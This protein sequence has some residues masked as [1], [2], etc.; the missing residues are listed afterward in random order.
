MAEIIGRQIEFGVATE[1]TRGTAE[2]AA[3]KWARQ[4]SATVVE[5][6]THAVDD[7]T[8]GRIEAG[9]GR[10]VT[11]K[12]IEGQI[13]GILHIDT[14]GW[15]LSNI[16]GICNST[17]VDDPITDHVFT[18]KQ[19]IEHTSLSLFAKDGTVQQHVFNNCMV[20][21]LT[22]NAAIDAY[23]R[24]TATFIGSDAAT[25]SDTPSYDT[26]YDFVARDL[27]VKVATSEAGLTGASALPVKAFDITWDQGLIRDHTAGQYGPADVYNSQLMIEGTLTLNFVD[28]TFKDYYLGNDALYM[29][30][31]IQGEADLGTGNNP[32]ITILLN[33][34]QWMDWS[35]TS[36]QGELVTQPL[37]FRAF[38]NQTDQQQSQVTLRNMTTAYTNVP[39]S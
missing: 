15:Y 36:E 5:K 4:V 13:D 37:P 25:N 8:M 18:L 27:S 9:M 35:R 31:K 34:V 20:N 21:T 3:D 39:T 1:A 28:Q 12:F 29:E 38:L 23:V 7:T 19:N 14:L 22:L 6:A 33:K 32:T 16:Y 2:T 17:E 24:H 11:Q 30:V 10:R 26:E